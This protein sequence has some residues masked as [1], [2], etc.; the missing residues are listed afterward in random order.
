MF[1]QLSN[2]YG[3]RDIPTQKHVQT[4]GFRLKTYQKL[5]C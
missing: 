2:A 1:E 3:T 4:A 5:R